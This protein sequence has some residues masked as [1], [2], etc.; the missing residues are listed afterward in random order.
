MTESDVSRSPH[1]SS[2]PIGRAKRAESNLK[3]LLLAPSSD[4]RGPIGMIASHLVSELEILNCTVLRLS[5]GNDEKGT[6]TLRRIENRFSQLRRAAAEIRTGNFDV[7]IIKTA[8]DWLTLTRDIPML[9]ISRLFRTPAVLHFHGSRPENIRTERP[10]D[11]FTVFSRLLARLACG[12]LVLSEEEKV[13]WSDRTHARGVR[14]VRNPYVQRFTDRDFHSTIDGPSKLIFV[15]R[16]IE[17]KGVLDL[18]S[19]MAYV[20][21]TS[22]RVTIIGEGRALEEAIRLAGSLNVEI[23]TT[24]YL[25]GDLLDH[26]FRSA[27]ALALPSWSEG[28][29]TVIS[30]AMDAGLGIIT[31]PIRGVA[32]WL[33][34][35]VNVLYVSP[36][37]PHDIARALSELESQALR[38]HMAKANRAMLSNFEP[39]AVAKDYL[40]SLL[41]LIS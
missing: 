17:E 30:E 15:G 19:A 40:S 36:R 10:Y 23:S 21:A 5:W 32:D 8:H 2:L 3:I 41:A 18:V 1:S 33:R 12:L 24:G 4:S 20:P 22:W 31:T 25:S 39:S 6:S 34:D 28:F 29:P 37:S 13:Q 35:G 38:R 16:V 9:L 26:E 11:P 7:F 14:V 27:D